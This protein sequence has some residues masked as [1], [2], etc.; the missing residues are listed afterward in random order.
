ME[1]S[2]N[3]DLVLSCGW[4][5]RILCVALTPSPHPS[6]SSHRPLNPATSH[7]NNNNGGLHACVRAAEDIQ[8]I[9]VTR[10]KYSAPLPLCWVKKDYGQPTSHFRLLF[11]V[12]SSS[13]FMRYPS[14]LRFWWVSSTT[15]RPGIWIT[16]C[17]VIYSGSIWTQIF[18]KRF[19][20]RR[21]KKIV[22][23]C[24]DMA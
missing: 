20:W 5:I 21:G 9:K 3:T 22:L 18:L 16:V 24:V 10:I 2:D 23:V 8:P 7:N 19:Q 6:T 17:W 12:F 14:L 4:W 13:S 1:K 15:Y 11:V